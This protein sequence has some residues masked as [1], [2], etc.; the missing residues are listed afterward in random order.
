MRPQTPVLEMS[1]RFSFVIFAI[2]LTLLAFE[3][4]SA[5]GQADATKRKEF[6]VADMS[7]P[8]VIVHPY[9][10]GLICAEFAGGQLTG[11]IRLLSKED[12]DL[13]LSLKKVGPLK[14]PPAARRVA[15]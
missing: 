11:Q 4:A 2:M 7:P 5:A 9:G 14:S 12:R 13:K 6:L 15:E 3:V 1:P 10:D 8:C